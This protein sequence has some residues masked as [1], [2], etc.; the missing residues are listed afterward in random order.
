[1]VD[2]V[3][4]EKLAQDKLKLDKEVKEFK[5]QVIDEIT[6]LFRCIRAFSSA[7]KVIFNG[8]EWGTDDF[9]QTVINT[10]ERLD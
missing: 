10:L 4:F 1:M 9:M 8:E 2:F 5:V 3:K 7:D 6:S